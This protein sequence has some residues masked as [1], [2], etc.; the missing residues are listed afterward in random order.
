METMDRITKKILKIKFFE[1]FG[2][3]II[4]FFQTHEAKCNSHAFDQSKG[5]TYSRMYAF[6]SI[7]PGE[8]DITNKAVIHSRVEKE[9]VDC[10]NA[11]HIP[12]KA[13]LDSWNTYLNR[14]SKMAL[15]NIYIETNIGRFNLEN[16]ATCN[17]IH[18]LKTTQSLVK[19]EIEWFSSSKLIPSHLKSKPSTAAINNFK[20]LLFHHQ[21]DKKLKDI[22]QSPDSLASICGNRDIN[23][24]QVSWVIDKINSSQVRGHCILT[25]DTRDPVTYIRHH[26]Q[27]P[28]AV[29]YLGLIINVGKTAD[30]SVY[31]GGWYNEGSHWTMAL[32]LRSSNTLIY[33]DSSGW[34]MPEGLLEYEQSFHHGLGSQNAPLPESLYAHDPAGTSVRGHRCLEG[35]CITNYPFQRCSNICG[36]VAT[37]MMAIAMI[38]PTTFSDILKM[39]KPYFMRNPTKYSKYLRLVLMAWISEN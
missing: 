33:F 38:D 11:K 14:V 28:E 24:D 20:S 25:S 21:H 34:T 9:I 16:I 18:Q 7:L 8:I 23:S 13:S 15:E 27:E 30:G 2:Q 37:E 3:N 39:Q 4:I 31:M 1:N 36:V 35:K 6:E 10:F 19:F 22:N 29:E 17:L 5:S 26:I 12:D 32:L